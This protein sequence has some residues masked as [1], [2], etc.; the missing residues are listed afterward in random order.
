MI[1]PLCFMHTCMHPHGCHAVAAHLRVILAVQLGMML[2]VET[3][4][5][6]Q[7]EIAQ[8]GK[9]QQLQKALGLLA[10]CLH[11]QSI[12]DCEP[13]MEALVYMMGDQVVKVSSL[14]WQLR[15]TWCSPTLINV[16]T[17]PQVS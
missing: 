16:M 6:R 1:C 2:L 13:L 17:S 3:D 7:A 5:S 9:L 12:E 8:L 14:Y 15:T 10:D 11:E 4:W